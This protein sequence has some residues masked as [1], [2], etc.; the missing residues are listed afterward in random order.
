MQDEM[1]QLRRLLKEHPMYPKLRD[2]EALKT[3]MQWHVFAVW[4]FMSLLK[5]LQS[6]ITCVSVPWKPSTY[7]PELVRLINEIVLAE[8]S[9]VD[10]NG[11]ASSHFDLYLKAMEEVGADTSMIKSFIKEPDLNMLPLEMKEVISYHLELA[12]SDDSNVHEIASSFFF[13]REKLIPEMF[14]SIVKI[15]KE[16]KINAPTLLYYFERHI[17]L[18]GD[19]HGPKAQKCLEQLCD[20][21]AKQEQ[22]HLVAISSLQMR[23]KLWD[24]IASTIA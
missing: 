9:D 14:D 6:K 17:E 8:E 23:V 20:S 3:F 4:D 24:F 19:E 21:P 10:L 7:S 1:A 12:K 13:G 2:I 5:S 18:D 16:N 22:A 15:L 11:N